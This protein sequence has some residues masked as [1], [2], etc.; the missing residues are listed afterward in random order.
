MER[1]ALQLLQRIK[2]LK[3]QINTKEFC[4]LH[5]ISESKFSR[6]PSDKFIKELELLDYMEQF[7]NYK[8]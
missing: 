1:R 7:Y 3:R 6:L 8:L 5:G 2:F 4:E